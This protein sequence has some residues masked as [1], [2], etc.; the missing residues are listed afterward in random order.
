M[1]SLGYA[2]ANEAF[3]RAQ[4][5]GQG[6]GKVWFDDIL[7]DGSEETLLDCSH[8]GVGIHNCRHSEDAGVNCSSEFN[9]MSV[10]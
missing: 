1:Y 5:F 8:S 6:S 4:P 7:C 10:L 2:S 3:R 9:I